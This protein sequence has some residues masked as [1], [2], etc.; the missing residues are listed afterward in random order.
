MVISGIC[1][2]EPPV[3]AITDLIAISKHLYVPSILFFHLQCTVA[4]VLSWVIGELPSNI[5]DSH[6]F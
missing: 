2:A 3:S 5:S 6:A 1:G 4:S